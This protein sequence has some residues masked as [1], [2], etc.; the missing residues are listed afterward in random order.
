[1]GEINP[2]KRGIVCGYLF[3]AGPFTRQ[4]PVSV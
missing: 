1:M 4:A 3:L 2:E